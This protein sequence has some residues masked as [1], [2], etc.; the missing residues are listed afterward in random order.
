MEAHQL[1][2]FGTTI[3]YL[4]AYYFIF[5]SGIVLVIFLVSVTMDSKYPTKAAVIKTPAMVVASDEDTK[6]RYLLKDIE[7]DD[8]PLNGSYVGED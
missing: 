7:F 4:L 5:I 1:I 3:F 2:H 8:L 6:L